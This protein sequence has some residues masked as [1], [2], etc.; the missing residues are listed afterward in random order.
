[1]KLPSE[2][3]GN[4]HKGRHAPAHMGC[5]PMGGGEGLWAEDKKGDVKKKKQRGEEKDS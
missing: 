5:E 4:F 2:W 1:M 3:C